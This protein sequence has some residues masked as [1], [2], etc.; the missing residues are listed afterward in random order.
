MVVGKE[1]LHLLSASVQELVGP[2]DLFLGRRDL[3]WRCLLLALAHWVLPYGFREAKLPLYMYLRTSLEPVNEGC[4]KKPK[5][6]GPSSWGG[7]P[8]TPGG[9][10]LAQNTRSADPVVVRPG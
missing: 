4:R 8:G 7:T 10:C 6:L 1:L 9:T 5:N 2:I 3:F